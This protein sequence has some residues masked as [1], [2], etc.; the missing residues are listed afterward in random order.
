MRYESNRGD[1]RLNPPG[2]LSLVPETNHLFN[3]VDF[4]DF[5]TSDDGGDFDGG[6]L[7]NL[8][9]AQTF[10]FTSNGIIEDITFFDVSGREYILSGFSMV[11]RGRSIHWFLVAGEVLS[12]EEWELRAQNAHEID[13]NNITPWKRAFLKESVERAGASTGARRN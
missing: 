4:L 2:Y 3:I 8:P 7:A 12:Q 1:D 10:H 6:D 13:L 5:I 9:E 11:R